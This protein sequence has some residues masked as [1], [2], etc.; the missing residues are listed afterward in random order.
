MISSSSVNQRLHQI[1]DEST[2]ISLAKRILA[3]VL[4]H[5][6][7]YIVPC[8]SS[9]NVPSS[10]CDAKSSTDQCLRL[11]LCCIRFLLIMSRSNEGIRILRLQMRLETEDDEPSRWSQSSIGCMTAVLHGTLSYAMQ[12]D[13][14]DNIPPYPTGVA[15]ALTLIVDLCINFFKRLVLFVEQ[16]RGLSPKATTFLLLTSE[17]R[18]IFQSCCQRILAHQSPN[19][20]SD[21]PTLL[22]FR[23]ELKSDVRYLFE[24]LVLVTEKEKGDE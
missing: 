20:V 8:L 21:P 15:R 22:H 14:M 10:D 12:L 4:D 18:T 9:G 19:A 5:M 11:C 3:A 23:E 24:E 1:A 2:K 6:D 7:E 16:Q 17:H 13:E